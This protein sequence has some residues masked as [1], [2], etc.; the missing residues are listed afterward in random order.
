MSPALEGEFLTTGPP[1]VLPSPRDL[2]LSILN[3]VFPL[4]QVCTIPL[5]LLWM[6]CILNYNLL[7]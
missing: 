7:H 4:A 1:E 5:K 2:S 6:F 3:I